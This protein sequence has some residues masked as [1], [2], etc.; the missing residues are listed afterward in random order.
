M[1]QKEENYI[2]YVLT[3][4]AILGLLIKLYLSSIVNVENS[5]YKAESTIIGYGLVL[6]CVSALIFF[7]INVKENVNALEFMKIFFKQSLPY[8]LVISLL[9]FIIYLNVKFID[10]INSGNV[11]DQFNT[12]S[13]VSTFMFLFQL[14][15]LYKYF[16]LSLESK[17]NKNSSIESEKKKFKMMSYVFT[18]I[19]FSLVG[20]IY[21]ILNH[22]LTDG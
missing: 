19:N 13:G 10:K 4:I 9:S 12:I 14:Y 1:N 7:K 2:K 15:F 20:I 21:I 6:C 11:G 8:L 22:F 17:Y 3:S 16:S 18:P 5:N